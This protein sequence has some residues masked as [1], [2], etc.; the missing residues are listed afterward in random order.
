[1][2]NVMIFAFLFVSLCIQAAYGQSFKV[3]EISGDLSS[4]VIHEQASG[5]EWLVEK[6]DVI[7]GWM[8]EEIGPSH[9]TL[10]EPQYDGSLMVIELAAPQVIQSTRPR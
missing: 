2:K 3:V 8:V 10:S 5:Q 9:V 1:M 7:E 6:G 4:A